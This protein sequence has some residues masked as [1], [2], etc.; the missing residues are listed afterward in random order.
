MYA[1]ATLML[2]P[3]MPSS[4]RLASST[5]SELASP[6]MISAPAVPAIESSSTGLRPQTSES[7]PRIGV[8][9]TC[10]SGY[11]EKMRPATAGPAPNCLA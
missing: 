4:M 8:A 1:C 7:L 10:M 5:H 9:M 11:D 6:S 2:P 3:V